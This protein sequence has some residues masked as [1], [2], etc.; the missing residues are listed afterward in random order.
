MFGRLLYK[1]TKKYVYVIL[2]SQNVPTGLNF[3]TPGMQSLMQQ[4]TSN[5]SMLQN[6]M[7]APYMQAMMQSM[8]ANPDLAR[9]LL[10]QNPLYAANPQLGNQIAQVLRLLHEKV[11]QGR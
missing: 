7:N 8:A 4:I 9:N 3:N 1:S 6:M 5:P 11:G 10:Q 2:P